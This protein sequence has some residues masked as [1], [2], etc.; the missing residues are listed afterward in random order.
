MGKQGQSLPYRH[1]QQQN[2]KTKGVGTVDK[3]HKVICIFLK[4]FQTTAI[5]T[6]VG[7]C[8]LFSTKVPCLRV[9]RDVLRALSL[10]HDVGCMTNVSSPFFCRWH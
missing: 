6:D 8:T 1:I 9:S 4:T 3:L 5:K 10:I 7:Q 2:L